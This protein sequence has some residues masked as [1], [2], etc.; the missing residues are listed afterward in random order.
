MCA[1]RSW[2]SETLPVSRIVLENFAGRKG[3]ISIPELGHCDCGSSTKSLEADSVVA[4][5]TS[6]IAAESSSVCTVATVGEDQRTY[7]CMA[8]APATAAMVLT[9][10]NGHR[11]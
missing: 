1:I 2:F 5:A 4:F 9:N 7:Q 8:N 6:T 10:S 3:S 11:P